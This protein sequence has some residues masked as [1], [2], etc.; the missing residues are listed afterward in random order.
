MKRRWLLL[1]AL[2]VAACENSVAGPIPVDSRPCVVAVPSDVVLGAAPS[3]ESMRTALTFAGTLIPTLGAGPQAQTLSTAIL[4]MSAS[5]A[6]P[7]FDQSCHLFN[8]AMSAFASLP[9]DPAT[10]PTRAAIRMT[11]GLAAQAIA[12]EQSVAH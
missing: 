9:N 11:L 1:F 10:M 7:T 2:P 12:R 4:A 3:V 6:T 5:G 8:D